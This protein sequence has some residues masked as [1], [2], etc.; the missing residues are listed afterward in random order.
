MLASLTLFDLKEMAA[1]VVVEQFRWVLG[2]QVTELGFVAGI[3]VV[4]SGQSTGS[5]LDFGKCGCRTK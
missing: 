4:A 5:C 3:A 2:E 1:V